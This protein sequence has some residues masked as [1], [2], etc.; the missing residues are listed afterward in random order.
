MVAVFNPSVA[1]VLKAFGCGIR[2][3]NFEV[4][5]EE[6][7]PLR[8][9]SPGFNASPNTLKLCRGPVAPGTVVQSRGFPSRSTTGEMRLVPEPLGV[10]SALPLLTPG[11]NLNIP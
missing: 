4:N 6:S 10:T 11:K 5:P 7:S 8:K 2:P 3:N 9:G 1:A